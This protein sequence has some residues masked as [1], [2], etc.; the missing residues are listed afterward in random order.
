VRA[1]RGLG[2]LLCALALCV[3]SAPVGAEDQAPVPREGARHAVP[4]YGELVR[5]YDAPDNPFAPGHRGVKVG[6]EVGTPVRASDGGV[7]SFAGVV[8]DNRAVTVDHGGGLVTTYSYLATIEVSRGDVVEQGDVVGT[9]GEG[10]P[11]EDLPPHVHLSARRDGVY[12]DPLELYV[13]IDHSELLSL[14]R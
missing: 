7:V 6:A 8:V 13:G 5:P 14:T 3:V 11:G 10:K 1:I 4:L 2:C 12:F 9:L